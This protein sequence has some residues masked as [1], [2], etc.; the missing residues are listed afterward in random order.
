MIRMESANNENFDKSSVQF[1]VGG[2][3]GGHAVSNGTRYNAGNTD[4]G[5]FNIS[6]TFNS[7]EYCESTKYAAADVDILCGTAGMDVLLGDN[8]KIVTSDGAKTVVSIDTHAWQQQVIGGPDL[9][10]G[11]DADDICIGGPGDDYVDGGS[12]S[13]RLFG[14]NAAYTVAAATEKRFSTVFAQFPG[15]R[16]ERRYQRVPLSFNDKIVAGDGDD[17]IHGGEGDD[18]LLGGEGLND[19]VGGHSLAHG[20]DGADVIV[21]GNDSDAILGDN[22][23]IERTLVGCTKAAPWASNCTWLMEHS[24]ERPVRTIIQHDAEDGQ[25][26]GD[27]IH[28]GGGDDVIYSQRGNDKVYAGAGN[29]EVALGSGSDTGEGGSGDDVVCGE[30]C[31]FV[32]VPHHVNPNNYTVNVV[33]EKF[34][35]LEHS[36]KMSKHVCPVA[37]DATVIHEA[38]YIFVGGEIEDKTHVRKEDG[39]KW[40]TH[41]SSLHESI[42]PADTFDDT[43]SGGRGDDFL[44]GQAG[45]DSL[46]GGDGDDIV[47][48]DNAD[49][50]APGSRTW[51]LSSVTIRVQRDESNGARVQ[52]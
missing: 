50:D 32:R 3:N 9:I 21:S 27:E 2:P 45:D 51:A 18:I 25:G 26:G 37:S 34:V 33:L 12:G 47:I 41:M 8:G 43:I 36:W 10:F 30:N 13:N 23:V 19:I 48:G 39:G 17:F 28:S 5:K 20:G 15:T 11:G 6:G 38:D 31:M 44:I 4:D 49:I 14:D 42:W 22:G 29:D 46:C 24:S 7:A 1:L 16:R 40:N 35:Q 52:S